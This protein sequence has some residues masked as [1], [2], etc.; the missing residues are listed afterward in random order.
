[1]ITNTKA[2]W[3]TQDDSFMFLVCKGKDIVEHTNGG[4]FM[5][6]HFSMQEVDCVHFSQLVDHCVT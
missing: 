5:C 1:M 4:K 3:N 2:H 6:L